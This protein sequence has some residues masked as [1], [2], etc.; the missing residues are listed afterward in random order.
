MSTETEHGG[1]AAT[2]RTGGALARKILAA[3]IKLM[4]IPVAKRDDDWSKNIGVI[5]QA[6]DLLAQ[7]RRAKAGKVLA[8]AVKAMEA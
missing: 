6:G 5:R 8:G 2:R 7:G 3:E 4:A 1:Y